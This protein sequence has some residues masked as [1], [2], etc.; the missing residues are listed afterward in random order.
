MT[1]SPDPMNPFSFLC[2]VRLWACGL[3][4]IL[5]LF[6][7]PL[8]AQTATAGPPIIEIKADPG[9]FGLLGSSMDY[10]LSGKRITDYGE[11]KKIIYPLGDL[12]ASDLIRSAEETHRASQ[13]IY[14][15][16]AAVGIDIALL[17]KPVPLLYV[18]WFDR[19]ST[20]LAAAQII[21]TAST[22]LEANSE[23]KKFDA[24]QRYDRLVKAQKGYAL[25][26]Q[27]QLFAER[28]NVGLGMKCSF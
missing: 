11:F 4:L 19:I 2:A 6:P 7:W 16:G 5:W 15:T 23:G 22:L 26:I 13:I 25:D 14:Y 12:E 20:G 9:F 28:D 10:T 18:D 8:Q 1:S 17:Y 24:V 3:P 21:W 27:P